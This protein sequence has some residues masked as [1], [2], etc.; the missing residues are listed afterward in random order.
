MR[1][2]RL[3]IKKARTAL[4]AFAAELDAESKEIIKLIAA[5]GEAHGDATGLIDA[6]QVAFAKRAA[7]DE[8]V[9][10]PHA[11]ETLTKKEQRQALA[12]AQLRT[13]VLETLLARAAAIADQPGRR[14]WCE[15]AGGEAAAL[16]ADEKALRAAFRPAELRALQRDAANVRADVAAAFTPR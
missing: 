8:E 15:L 11:E 5:I 7:V 10:F 14:A 1:K 12:R 4:P 13:R 9:V 3:P 6:L 2:A 16:F